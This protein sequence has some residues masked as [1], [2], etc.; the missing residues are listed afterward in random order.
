[1]FNYKHEIECWLDAMNIHNYT[2]NDDLTVDVAGCVD[3]ERCWLKELPVQF[4]KVEGFFDCANN[5]LTSLK[6]C[7]VEIVNGY[8]AC[9]HNQLI[10]LEHAPKKVGG[11]FYCSNNKLNSLR[12]MPKHINGDFEFY[13]NEFDSEEFDDMDLHQIHQYYTSIDLSEKINNELP[14][15][16]QN[17]PVRKMKL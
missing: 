3:L 5:Q 4:G 7:P 10:S 1:M 14:Q 11:D 2:I 15:S 16:K 13:E 9:H 17:K 8:F 6:G 12:H